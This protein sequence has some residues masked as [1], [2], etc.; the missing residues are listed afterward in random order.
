V[1]QLT[2]QNH[3]WTR[4]GQKES[5]Y[6]PHP[7]QM[8]AHQALEKI[9][10][11][12]WARRGGKG[13]FVTFEMLEDFF[14]L[15]QRPRDP[16]LAPPFWAVIVAPDYKMAAQPWADLCTFLPAEVI[17]HMTQDDKKIW[18]K[19]QGYLNAAYGKWPNGDTR[20]IGGLIE[21][22]SADN[23]K[24][25][26]GFGADVLCIHEAQEISRRAFGL[27]LPT[28]ISP[29]R[30]GRLLIE[31][32][33]A[34]F[35][36]H[37]TNDYFEWG[38]QRINGVFSSRQTYI[39]NPMLTDD[40]K[41]QIEGLRAVYL[42]D[43]WERMYM[44]RDPQESEKAMNIGPC[45]VNPINWERQKPKEGVDYDIG[46]DLGKRISDTVI[47]VWDKSVL[48][49]RLAYY[50]R[51]STK[52]DWPVQEAAIIALS[53]HWIKRSGAFGRPTGSI[54]LDV[55]GPGDPI[56]DSLKL[57]GLPVVPVQLTGGP[58]HERDRLL[59]RLAIALEKGRLKIPRE[60]RI[61]RDF[62]SMR[63]VKAKGVSGVVRWEV[64][65]GGRADSV[66]STAM[67]IMDLPL[68]EVV[69]LPR[70]APVYFGMGAT[71]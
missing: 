69:P 3:T 55:G 22:R 23:E 52:M 7:G 38:Q 2:L 11:L 49:W 66:F 64:R 47:T 1:P 53:D 18:L 6:S 62:N 29:G 9:K 24:A 33:P 67:G 43:E 8:E 63:R 34:E 28:T 16:S 65:E 56:Y 60:E 14:D 30:S 51:I 41:V 5:V 54:Y 35:A 10:A 68:D 4:Q 27:L 20:Y 26:Q 44:A 46:V 12:K 58:L 70:K 15:A 36:D 71:A 31:G 50:R 39:D 37:W 57:R 19:P 17:Q 59:N 21:V 25:L 40:Q 32:I 13:R 42:E 45:L 61:I 48:P